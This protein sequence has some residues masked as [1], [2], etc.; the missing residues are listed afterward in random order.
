M[1]ISFI[2]TIKK[3]P[4]KLIQKV[5]QQKPKNLNELLELLGYSDNHKPFIIATAGG[6]KLKNTSSLTPDMEIE[7]TVLVGGG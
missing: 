3:P 1:K 5:E 7:L 6:K 4:L 2:G